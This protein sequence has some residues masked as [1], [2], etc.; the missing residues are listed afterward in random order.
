MKERLEA[1]EPVMADEYLR[2]ARAV[3]SQLE[4]LLAGRTVWIKPAPLENTSYY[5]TLCERDGF[6]E[7]QRMVLIRLVDGEGNNI[8]G[9]PSGGTFFYRPES[10]EIPVK[11]SGVIVNNTHRVKA[12][13]T[14]PP[15]R[16]LS[17]IMAPVEDAMCMYLAE[18]LGKSV[19]RTLHTSEPGNSRFV[20]N[21]R[22]RGYGASSNI[23]V[24]EGLTLKKLFF[25]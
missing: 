14:K 8:N 21:Y 22:D 15:L 11:V 4:G 7:G 17:G 20:S 16:N 25:S 23:G 13:V 18:A 19:E 9:H 2:S 12:L 24:S 1:I 10:V 3:L 5:L 6:D